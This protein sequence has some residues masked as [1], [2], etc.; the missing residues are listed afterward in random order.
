[1]KA[2]Q[3]KPETMAGMH[4]V[5]LSLPIETT[6]SEPARVKIEYIS[7][8]KGAEILGRPL[9]LNSRE[10]PDRMAVSTELIELTSHTGTHVDAPAHYG[11]LCEGR[12]SKSIEN[13][14]LEW[15]FQDGVLIDCTGDA[16]SGP[17]TLEE[18][19]RGCEN[20]AYRI[21]PDDIVL[22]RTGADLLWGTAEYFTNF[23]GVT[24]NALTWILSHGVKVVGIDS[25][26]F[27]PPFQ[28]MLE[29][30]AAT[31]DK[32]CL[33]PTHV[34]GRNKEYCQIERLANLEKLPSA[35]GFKVACFP[36][37]IR[38][39]GAGWTR[40]VAIYGYNDDITT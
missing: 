28:S 12:P 34:F 17:V 30:F 20:L 26:G 8:E 1:M 16:S 19:R 38:N 27:D 6:Q 9:N 7:H 14:P 5:D 29:T 37:K 36:V 32:R 15:F 23:R 39:A 35:T 22:I 18:I 10:W 3:R 40:V 11:P 33:W 2:R 25:F 21:K 31:G 13:V 24:V 4:F